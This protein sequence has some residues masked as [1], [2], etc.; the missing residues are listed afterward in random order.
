MHDFVKEDKVIASCPAVRLSGA[1][2]CLECTS[3]ARP[4]SRERV[5]RPMEHCVVKPQ[6]NRRGGRNAGRTTENT[7]N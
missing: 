3:F 1:R 4:P 6:G 7:S 2:E 5:A